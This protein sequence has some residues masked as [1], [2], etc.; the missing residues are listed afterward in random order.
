[1][2]QVEPHLIKKGSKHPKSFIQWWNCLAHS[3]VLV[4]ITQAK[5]KHGSKILTFT[6]SIKLV[7]M[8]IAIIASNFYNGLK[9]LTNIYQGPP[10]RNE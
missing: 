2:G 6:G 7:I 3:R 1:M 4:S 8:I 9:F 10:N 5:Y